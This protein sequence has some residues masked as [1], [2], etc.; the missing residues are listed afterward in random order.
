MPKFHTQPYSI[1]ILCSTPFHSNSISWS[2]TISLSV[3]VSIY[4]HPKSATPSC[5]LSVLFGRLLGTVTV[6]HRRCKDLELSDKLAEYSSQ[7]N[8]LP[9]MSVVFIIVENQGDCGKRI[10]LHPSYHYRAGGKGT[11]GTAMAVPVFE[12]GKM[13]SLGFSCVIEWPLRAVRRSLGDLRTFFKL[14]SMQS[15]DER[16]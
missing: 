15:S 13:A 3:T 2:V 12:G 4:L 6:L 9:V 7:S 14:S 1:P 10:Q 8:G 5:L 11:A 16:I